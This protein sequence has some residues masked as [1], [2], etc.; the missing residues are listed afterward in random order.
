ML[1]FIGRWWR[2]N[3][4]RV[5]MQILWPQFVENSSDIDHAKAGFMLHTSMDSAWHTDF[6]QEE[7]IGFIDQLTSDT[8]D[9]L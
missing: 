4:R 2:K 7:R 8:R 6:S 3:Q 1:D 9:P 5:D